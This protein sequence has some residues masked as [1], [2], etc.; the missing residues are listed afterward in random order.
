M[1]SFVFVVIVCEKQ[2]GPYS[3]EDEEDKY[4]QKE[5]PLCDVWTYS[6]CRRTAKLK[7]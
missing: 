6:F 7:I 5:V 3:A 2:E 4:T 1:G